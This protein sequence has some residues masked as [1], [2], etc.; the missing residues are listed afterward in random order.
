MEKGIGCGS[1]FTPIHLQPFYVETF[2]YKK[3]D[4]PVAEHVSERTIALP[5]H[6]NL[7]ETEVDYVVKNV[8]EAIS[9]I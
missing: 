9:S 4:Y 7:S 3:G 1:Y 6:G 8:E 5:F 2:G